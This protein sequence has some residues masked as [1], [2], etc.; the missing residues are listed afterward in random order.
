MP[1]SGQLPL[2]GMEPPDVAGSGRV[3]EAQADYISAEIDTSF[4]GVQRSTRPAASGWI[5]LLL[6]GCYG[7]TVH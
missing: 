1:T 2:A 3:G 5:Y 4:A 6:G 7:Y